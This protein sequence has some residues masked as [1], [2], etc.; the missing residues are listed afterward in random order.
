MK[1]ALPSVADL[2]GLLNRTIQRIVKL[3]TRTGYL[4]EEQGM[5]Y[6]LAIAPSSAKRVSE[7]GIHFRCLDNQMR[8]ATPFDMRLLFNRGWPAV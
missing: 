3:L 4:I 6:R 5:S 2:E 7:V 1:R 8:T